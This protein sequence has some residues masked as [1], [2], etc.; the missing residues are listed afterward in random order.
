MTGRAFA[1]ASASFML[2]LGAY[3]AASCNSTAT[4]LTFSG[5]SGPPFLS[6]ISPLPCECV[7]DPDGGALT[8]PVSVDVGGTFNLR[9]PGTACEDTYNCGYVQLYVDNVLNN[10][11]GSAA[12][13]ALNLT[14]GVHTLTVQLV[15]D[16]NDAGGAEFFDAG[17]NPHAAMVNDSGVGSPP[18]TGLYTASVTIEVEP[19]CPILVNCDAGPTSAGTGGAPPTDAGG[20]GGAP[21]TDAGGSGDAGDAGSGG[22]GDAGMADAGTAD[23][24]T[25]DAGTGDAGDGG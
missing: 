17:F 12:V 8:V 3:G 15:F 13:T 16:I 10:A 25:A 1:F 5:Y 4:V 24:G 23:A 22:P 9:P 6:I 18:P 14:P 21:P 7:A 2:A 11:S 19:S 20:T